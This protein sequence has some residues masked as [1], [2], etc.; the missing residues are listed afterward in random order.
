[1]S[2]MPVA[3]M[4]PVEDDDQIHLGAVV[5]AAWRRPVKQRPEHY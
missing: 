3:S 2:W 5:R 4:M 1:M